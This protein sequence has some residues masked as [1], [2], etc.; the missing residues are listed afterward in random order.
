M[1]NKKQKASKPI[2][3]DKHE[4]EKLKKKVYEMSRV[5][6][7]IGQIAQCLG[8]KRDYFDRL[9]F[10][11]DLKDSI[12]KCKM[13]T[14]QELLN[15]LLDRARG[16]NVRAIELWL[17]KCCPEEYG[18]K[19]TIGAMEPLPV[20]ISA[21]MFKGTTDEEAAKIYANLMKS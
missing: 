14:V 19:L 13:E 10:K 1:R 9:S 12:K 11:Y 5:G 15:V 7:T 17:T 3:L 16:G 18:N 6:M 4:T 8:M 2:R 20:D 21:K